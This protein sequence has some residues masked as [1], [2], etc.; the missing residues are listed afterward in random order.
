MHQICQALAFLHR[1]NVAH[2]DLKPENL[3]YTTEVGGKLKLTDFGFA[4]EVG[5]AKK[6]VL[7][8]FLC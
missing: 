7:N 2:R 4:K 5:Q 3:L 1:L 6:V 8:I